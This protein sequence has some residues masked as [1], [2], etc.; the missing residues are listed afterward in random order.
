VKRR[1]LKLAKIAAAVLA[2]VA[3][4]CGWC[5]YCA[6]KFVPLVGMDTSHRY[7]LYRWTNRP[8][9]AGPAVVTRDGLHYFFVKVGQPSEEI[10]IPQ[11]RFLDYLLY[12]TNGTDGSDLDVSDKTVIVNGCMRFD[13][14]G[15]DGHDHAEYRLPDG[16]GIPHA[17]N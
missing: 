11:G 12:D 15:P 10:D 13:I 17:R 3:F 5:F 4:L 7:Y 2:A 14:G 6:F 1:I 9:G 8:I 16:A